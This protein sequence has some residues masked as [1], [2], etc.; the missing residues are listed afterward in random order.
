MIEFENET[1]KNIEKVEID[2]SGQLE[3]LAGIKWKN[4]YCVL[5]G[6]TLYYYKDDKDTIPI[7][8]F[9]VNSTSIIEIDKVVKKPFPIHIAIG[10]KHHCFNAQSAADRGNK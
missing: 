7:G 8:D 6:G 2:K 4:N 3:R 9:S 1:I 5:R 10:K